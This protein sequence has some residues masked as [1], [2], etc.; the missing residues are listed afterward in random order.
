MIPLFLAGLPF[1]KLIELSWP[2]WLDTSFTPAT[3]A[4]LQTILISL[5][6]VYVPSIQHCL[7]FTPLN[8]HS[9]RITKLQPQPTN[10]AQPQRTH[11]HAPPLS[12]T[13]LFNQRNQ[14]DIS[15]PTFDLLS[16]RLIR[17]DALLRYNSLNQSEPL[18]INLFLLAS[19]SL[20]GYPLWCESVTG[21]V[22]TTSSSIG[23]A[24]V[25]VACAALFWRERSRRSNQ[26]RRMEK[27]LN[28]SSLSVRLPVNT[29]ISSVRPEAR[30]TELK[31]KRRIVAIRG[32]K[33][34]LQ[35][36][37]VI[38][39]LCFLRRRLIQS[40]TLVVLIPTE[41]MKSNNGWW[42]DSDQLG[43]ALWLGDACNLA[44]W[45]DYFNDLVEN[46]SNELAWF[47][48]N[49]NGRSIASGLNEAPRLLELLGQQ[50][51][52]MEILDESDEPEIVGGDKASIAMDILENQKQFYQVLTGSDN[53][54]EM[55]KVYSTKST[56]EVNEVCNDVCVYVHT[57]VTRCTNLNNLYPIYDFFN[58][59][60]VLAGGG[61][62]D[63]WSTCLEPSARP[64]G[65]TIS[66]SDVY[67][68]SPTIAYSTCI[69]FPTNAGIDGATLLAVQKWSREN[70]DKDWKLELHQTIP[71][72]SGSRAG[73]TLICDCRGCVA[74]A[75]ND[76][77]R[78]FGGL[79][80]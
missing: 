3:V 69:E 63:N 39:T 36:S 9:P 41:G 59:E 15:K 54:A 35:S 60:K 53:D 6:V 4:M 74:L 70:T 20:L 31:S 78:T 32:S 26:L 42:F 22:P 18:R 16:F 28:A 58:S 23:A 29:A 66:G 8:A 2:R 48:L 14:F 77:K 61:R 1:Q 46:P 72:S 21:D 64:S 56:E 73:G 12:K 47:A 25:G 68:S 44:E 55:Q 51:Q 43:D 80:G 10:N 65:M 30:L 79:I 19:I 52:P 57:L 17:S 37:G 76:E 71:W 45:E 5:F 50:L 49:F 67:I 11:H 62:I 24:G 7:A 13:R 34:Q 40:Q 33:E 38:D 27:E 75:R